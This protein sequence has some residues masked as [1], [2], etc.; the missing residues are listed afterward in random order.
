MNASEVVRWLLKMTPEAVKAVRM[1]RQ[2]CETRDELA[3][4]HS[5]LE[6]QLQLPRVPK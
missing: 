3:K 1:V 2:F 6:R 4:A 5:R